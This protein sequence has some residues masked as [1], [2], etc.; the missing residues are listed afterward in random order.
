MHKAA[1]SKKWTK[2]WKD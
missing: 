2:E 1:Q